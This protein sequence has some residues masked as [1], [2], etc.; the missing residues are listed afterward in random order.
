MQYAEGR[1]TE[2]YDIIKERDRDLAG[3][4]KEIEVVTKLCE[5]KKLEINEINKQMLR[6][7]D[8]KLDLEGKQ[9]EWDHRDHERKEEAIH[10]QDIIK[11]KDAAISQLS[12]TIMQTTKESARLTEMVSFFKNKLIVEN[13]FH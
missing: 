12:G 5:T 2:A 6:L 11:G 13:C 8:E 9:E 1:E 7:Q 10:L 3:K 4:L